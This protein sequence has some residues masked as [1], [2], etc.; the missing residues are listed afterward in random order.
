MNTNLTSFIKKHKSL[1][2]FTPEEKLDQISMA[3][4]I[5]TILNYGTMEDVCELFQLVGI[6]TVAEI[7]FDSIQQS[8][9]RRNNYF[10]DVENY[11]TLYFNKHVPGST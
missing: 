3:F 2:W 8:E 10:P 5:E 6:K 4:L 9:R 7:F 11:F 1:F